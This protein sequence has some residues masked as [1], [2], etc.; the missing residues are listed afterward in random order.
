[1]PNDPAQE[2]ARDNGWIRPD[3]ILRGVILENVCDLWEE[4][5]KP[6]DSKPSEGC[7]LWG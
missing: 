3:S 4:V 7:E 5:R 1:M 2:W 6:S